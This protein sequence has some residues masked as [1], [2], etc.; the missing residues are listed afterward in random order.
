VTHSTTTFSITAEYHYAECRNAKFHFCRYAE[1]CYAECRYAECHYAV[2]HGAVVYVYDKPRLLTTV[3][4]W[5]GW[6]L[7]TNFGGN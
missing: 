4:T 7:S 1:C 3:L 6:G 2:C 5:S